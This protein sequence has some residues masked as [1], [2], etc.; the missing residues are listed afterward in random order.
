[1]FPMHPALELEA[2]QAA[3]ESPGGLLDKLPGHADAGPAAEAAVPSAAAQGTV[4]DKR[5]EAS[6][7]KAKAR[8]R[9]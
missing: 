9:K 3:R 5:Q 8:R 6:R 1:M 4:A 7:R 2:D